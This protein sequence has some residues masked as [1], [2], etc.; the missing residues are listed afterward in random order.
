MDSILRKD[1]LRIINDAIYAVLPEDAVKEALKGF[2]FPKKILVLAVGK[3]A[4]RMANAASESLGD[5]IFEGLIITKYGHSRGSIEAFEIYEAGHPIPDDNTIRATEKALRMAQSINSENL[6]L[7]LVSGGGSSL[8]EMPAEEVQLK[9]IIDITEQL[10]MSDASIKDIN[11]VRKHLSKVKGGRFAQVV[12]PAKILSLVLSDVLKDELDT[13]ASGPAYPDHTTSQQAIDVIR[14]YKVKISDGALDALNL[15]T[16]KSLDNVQTKIVGNITMACQAAKCAAEKLGYHAVILTTTLN[17]HACEAGAFL[18]AIA[19][20]IVL[21]DQPVRKP[22]VI[23]VGGE[24][25][26]K[27]RGSGLGGRNQELAL[28]SAIGIEGLKNVVIASVATDG[29]DGPTEAAGGIVDGTT[30]SRLTNQGLSVTEILSNNDSYTALQ[31]I[32]DLI[33]TGP[34]GTNVNDLM[35]ILCK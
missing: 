21:S 4:W 29:T 5:N 23:I 22:C 11:A 14:K 33:I 32:G 8:F 28:S 3:A 25:V 7:F 19:N 10:L 35:L 24:T 1:T 12:S 13:I 34:T 16:P 15:E 2:V 31:L 27:V 6:L 17:C 30:I 20:E 26:V 9:D 18:S